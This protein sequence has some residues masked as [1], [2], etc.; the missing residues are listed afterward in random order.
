MKWEDLEPF[1]NRKI[2]PE[3]LKEK[4]LKNIVEKNLRKRMNKPLSELST[5]ER[6]ARIETT[7]P[8]EEIP[9]LTSKQVCQIMKELLKAFLKKIRKILEEKNSTKA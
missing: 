8:G 7:K 6:H 9:P 2:L 4:S 1:F 3:F 5:E